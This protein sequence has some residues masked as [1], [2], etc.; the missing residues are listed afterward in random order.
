MNAPQR[1]PLPRNPNFCSRSADPCGRQR[2]AAIAPPCSASTTSR[3]K[4]GGRTLLDHA[5][6]ALPAGARVGLVGRN[7]AG[8]T[9]LLR[10]IAGEIT[11]EGG[12][13]QLSVAQPDRPAGAGGAGRPRK[14]SRCRAR[15]RHRTRAPPPRSRDRARPRIELPR[16]RRGS[17]TSPPIPRLRARPQFSP[18]SASPMPTSSAPAAN[19]PAAGACA[20]GSQQ[21]CLPSPT[22]CCST[23]RPIISTSRPRS[24]SSSISAAI[25][26]P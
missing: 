15:G 4:I 24:G 2:S 11:P 10:I 17:R 14:P 6:A 23:S 1:R 13:V 3:C 21:R 5:T 19:S 9:T 12:E 18:A 22:C 8:K 7:G 20:L 16:S 26:T 25:R